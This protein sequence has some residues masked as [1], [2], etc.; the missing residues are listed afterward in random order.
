M[1]AFRLLGHD[2]ALTLAGKNLRYLR[3]Y[4]FRDD[5]SFLREPGDDM[6]V[7]F[8]EH[9]RAI[10]TMLEYAASSGDDE[11]MDFALR[12]FEWVRNLGVHPEGRVS[13]V[14][15]PGGPLVGYFPE[16]V[17]SVQWHASEMCNV[18]DM[19]ALAIRFSELGLGD[20][21]DDA[22]RWTRNM[23]AEGQLQTTDWIDRITEA[24][25]YN[26]LMNHAS[27]WADVDSFLPYEGRVEVRPKRDADLDIRIPEWVAPGDAECAVNG[28]RRDLAWAGRYA[29]VGQVSAS[30]RVL[31]TFPVGERTDVVYVEKHCYVL[32]RRGNDVVDI[33]PP[34]RYC[35]LYQRRNYR[36]GEPRL[37]PVTRFVSSENV[38][39]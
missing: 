30:G 7:H 14:W 2:A 8:H 3:R 21:W 15:Q 25:A 32:T 26:P 4:F 24:D 1:H 11:M 6:T 35:P 18:A 16:F 33:D 34:G 27:R 9:S 17:N 23:F 12:S 38:D 22:D 37:R 10:L 29:R 31:L 19:I 20:Y 28:V 36:D 13:S 5:G 39:W